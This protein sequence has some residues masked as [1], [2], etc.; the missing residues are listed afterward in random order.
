MFRKTSLLLPK[1]LSD[2]H[3]RDTNFPAWD[4]SDLWRLVFTWIQMYQAIGTTIPQ[5]SWDFGC[6]GLSHPKVPVTCWERQ[7]LEE[8]R[9]SPAS[10]WWQA[11]NRAWDTVSVLTTSQIVIDFKAKRQK[12][13]RPWIVGPPGYPV[14]DPTMTRLGQLTPFSMR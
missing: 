14:T 11:Y 13:Y 2:V 1:K 3:G 12:R 10:R 9:A 6:E 4:I 8:A 5:N 7:D